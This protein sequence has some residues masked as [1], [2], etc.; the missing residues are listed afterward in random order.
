M[1]KAMRDWMKG[2]FH[3]IAAVNACTCSREVCGP[4]FF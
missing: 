3:V 1:W 4:I 2:S